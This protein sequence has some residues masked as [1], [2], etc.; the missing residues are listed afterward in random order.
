MF[1][2]TSAEYA[3]CLPHIG[4]PLLLRYSGGWVLKRQIPGSE[5]HDVAG[6]YPLFC[7]Q[8]WRGLVEDIHELRDAGFISISAVIDP[9]HDVSQ[10]FLEQCFP[11]KLVPF[12][13]HYVVDLKGELNS[14]ISSHHRRYVRTSSRCTDIEEVSSGRDLAH[15]W[16]D[17]YS[18]LCTRRQIQGGF[19]MFNN[20]SLSAQLTMPG[21]VVLKASSRGVVTAMQIWV[22]NGE[23][24]Y[25]HLG[26][27]NEQ[28]Y[29]D[30]SSFALMWYALNKFKKEGASVADLGGGAGTKNDST[31]GL[32]R[33]K[34]GWSSE[35]RWA[36]FGG[37]ILSLDKYFELSKGKRDDYFPQ[38]RG[39]LVS[40]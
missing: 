40:A 37:V 3:S 24:V 32:A 22:R 13:Q 36:M 4:D 10:A 2:Y 17:L 18:M 12:K 19:A 39:G 9:F 31:S 20:A 16:L 23:Y 30:R 6:L 35:V 26:A 8:N 34:A 1:L 21:A 25:Y 7:C 15:D 29:K 28:G 11:N 14:I 5:N 33:F 38:Y 27:A